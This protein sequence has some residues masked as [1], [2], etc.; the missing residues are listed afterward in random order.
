MQ[1][2]P[3]RLDAGLVAGADVKALD[4]LDYPPQHYVGEE[5]WARLKQE[6]S[7]RRGSTGRRGS[8]VP[9]SYPKDLLGGQFS[10]ITS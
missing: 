2:P 7:G 4:I 6:L 10:T 3:D 1:K 5:A 9:E 8:K